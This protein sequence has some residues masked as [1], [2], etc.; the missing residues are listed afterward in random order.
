MCV[1]ISLSL[2]KPCKPVPSVF[3]VSHKLAKIFCLSL[4]L[5]PLAGW[6]VIVK[7]NPSCRT[8]VQVR[9]GLFHG[10]ELLC[11]PA[12]SN[13]SSGRSEHTWK[14]NIVEFE[15]SV[16]DLPR[17][18]RL[19]F[20]IY[21]VMDKVKKQ[22]ST[23]NPHINKYQTIRKAGKVVSGTHIIR[24]VPFFQTILY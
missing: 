13:E 10:T 23:K 20:A 14:D 6:L 21:A 9:A 16:C 5:W 22:K 15:I 24:Q 7:F 4:H 18:T 3:P 1:P 8:Q 11:K 17:M 19:C 2:H 12:V